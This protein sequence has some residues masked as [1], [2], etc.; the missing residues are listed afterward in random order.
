LLDV[1]TAEPSLLAIHVIDN[2]RSELRFRVSVQS[3]DKNEPL[4]ARL[5]A[6]YPNLNV[7]KRVVLDPGTFTE[8]RPITMTWSPSDTQSFPLAP[9]CHS[10]TLIVSHQ[11]APASV[12]PVQED[13]A[14]LVVW[15][16]VV[17]DPVDPTAAAQL[18]ILEECR[19]QIA[20]TLP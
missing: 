17:A 10:I 11:F 5:V 19:T 18:T 16:I 20:P 4:E 12:R 15:W 2:P 9:G 8:S 6:D 1:V 7:L 14:N 3:E 13:D